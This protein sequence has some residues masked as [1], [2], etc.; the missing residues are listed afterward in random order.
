M[1]G[2][3]NITSLPFRRS[4]IKPSEG[5]GLLS[6]VHSMWLFHGLHSTSG[7]LLTYF[8]S[9]ASMFMFFPQNTEI[10]SGFLLMSASSTQGLHFSDFWDIL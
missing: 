8:I 4:I 2:V 5:K 10:F 9:Y 3:I 6:K 1:A 7:I